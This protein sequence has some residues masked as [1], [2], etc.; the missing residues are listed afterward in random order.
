[1]QFSRSVFSLFPHYFFD[2]RE[3]SFS[4]WIS[5]RGTSVPSSHGGAVSRRSRSDAE[6]PLC[7]SQK[8][9]VMEEL[10]LSEG[11]GYSDPKCPSPHL[12]YTSVTR[13]LRCAVASEA[14]VC[15]NRGSRSIT[16]IVR[17]LSKLSLDPSD[18]FPMTIVDRRVSV[19]LS[20]RVRLGVRL[21]IMDA[22]QSRFCRM[23]GGVRRS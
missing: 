13:N 8:C 4:I 3:K 9:R 22:S 23:R 15:K 21:P 20:V 14:S 16:I 10:Q 12:P 17:K 7:P 18:T 2:F 1:M 6:P 11:I 19:C 5:N